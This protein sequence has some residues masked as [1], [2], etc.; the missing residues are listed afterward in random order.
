MGSIPS[1]EFCADLACSTHAYVRGC[2]P[3][4]TK[5]MH[6]RLINNHNL[7]VGVCVRLSASVFVLR[8]TG[9][10]SWV[11][12]ALAMLETAPLIYDPKVDEVVEEM[13]D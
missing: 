8:W 3:V 1:W 5:T 4:T 6:V 11:Y 7:P 2:P 13:N 9:G 12:P 10:L